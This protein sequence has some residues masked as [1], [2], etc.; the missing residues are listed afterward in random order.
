MLHA[1]TLTLIA[2]LMGLCI[3]MFG[4]PTVAVLMLIVC[5]AYLLILS[6]HPDKQRPH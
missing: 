5:V 6:D 3:L 4:I 1:A 2:L